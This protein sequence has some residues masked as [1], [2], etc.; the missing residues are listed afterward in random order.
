V[1]EVYDYLRLLYARIGT[2]YCPVHNIP[3][4]S[5]SI[6][7]MVNQVLELEP[8]TRI[9]ILSPIVRGEK[10]THKDKISD[11]IKNGYVRARIDSEEVDL[12]DEIN[13]EKNKKHNIDVI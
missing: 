10:G 9:R 13:L 5:Q 8:G 12:H 6:E 11:L 3:I 4:E 2:P 1:T 7:E